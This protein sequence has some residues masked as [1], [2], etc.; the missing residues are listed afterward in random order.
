[1]AASAA[2]A[3]S[4]THLRRQKDAPAAGGV[5]GGKKRG[6][7]TAPA[8]ERPARPGAGAS[9][10]RRAAQL[11]IGMPWIAAMGDLPAVTV[12]TPPQAHRSALGP[13]VLVFIRPLGRP[14]P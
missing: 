11:V 14:P 10:T 6:A 2:A 8:R 13:A 1:V 7:G 9:L 4:A 12:L 3:G 5:I